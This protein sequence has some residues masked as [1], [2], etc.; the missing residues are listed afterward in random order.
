MYLWHLDDAED[1]QR[2]GFIGNSTVS[3]DQSNQLQDWSLDV[4]VVAEGSRDSWL[5]VFS[6]HG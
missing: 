4:G 5:E 6:R 1:L 2:L 3:R